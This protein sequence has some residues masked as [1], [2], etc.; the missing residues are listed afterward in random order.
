MAVEHRENLEIV[1][2]AVFSSEARVLQFC[3]DFQI[4][5]LVFMGSYELMEKY[6]KVSAIPSKQPLTGS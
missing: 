3:S 2:A 5:Y 1:G 4:N 6:R